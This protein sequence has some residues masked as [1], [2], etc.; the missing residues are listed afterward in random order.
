M[1]VVYVLKSE[2]DG[3]LYIGCTGDIKERLKYHNEGK[4]RST[5]NRRPLILIFKE[6]YLDKYQAYNMERYYKSAKGK[7]EL[8]VKINLCGIV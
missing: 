4:V 7:K 5:R 8:K 6:E 1:H 2:K 3:N